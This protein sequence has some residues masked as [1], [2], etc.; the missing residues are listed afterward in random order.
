MP[1]SQRKA[2]QRSLRFHDTLDM[3]RSMVIYCLGLALLSV[4]VAGGNRGPWTVYPTYSDAARSLISPESRIAAGLRFS[5]AEADLISL[6]LIPGVSDTLATNLLARR[7]E[8]ERAGCQHMPAAIAFETAHG[9]GPVMAKT[10]TQYLELP[11]S[12]P[13]QERL[14]H[15]HTPP[16]SKPTS[17]RSKS[18]PLRRSAVR[19]DDSKRPRPTP[20]RAKHVAKTQQTYRARRAPQVRSTSAESRPRF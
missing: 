16:A 19:K 7:K 9:V 6:E 11:C 18:P 5:F 8:I 12:E 17:A 10:L 1:P 20:A 2:Q 4:I 15:P 14:N 13:E 3:Q